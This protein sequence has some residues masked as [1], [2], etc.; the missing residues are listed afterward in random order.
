MFLTHIDNTAGEKRH[1]LWDS[2]KAPLLREPQLPESLIGDKVFLHYVALEDT[3]GVSF[4]FDSDQLL[5]IVAHG[6][7]SNHGASYS[8]AID[9]ATWVHCPLRSK[10]EKI[11]EIWSIQHVVQ[12]L[13][14]RAFMVRKARR[15]L[16]RCMLIF[17]GPN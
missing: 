9:N 1:I 13:G 14:W 8:E 15:E 7:V 3:I 6:G 10:T 11:L 17:A 16:S 4:A 2:S 12:A 5:A